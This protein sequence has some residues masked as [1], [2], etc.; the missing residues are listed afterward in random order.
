[1]AQ[2]QFDLQTQFE[3]TSFDLF[4][5]PLS[6][7]SPVLSLDPSVQVPPNTSDQVKQTEHHTFS[8]D[9]TPPDNSHETPAHPNKQYEI[10]KDLPLV[11]HISTLFAI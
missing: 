1:M 9:N 11:T 6:N 8:K 10:M 4:T 2:A 3:K 7:D 5:Q